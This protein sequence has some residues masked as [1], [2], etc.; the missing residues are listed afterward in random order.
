MPVDRSPTAPLR[1]AIVAPSDFTPSPASTRA[2]STQSDAANQSRDVTV[3]AVLQADNPAPEYPPDLLGRR[4][5]GRV[6][7]EFV[8]DERGRVDTRTLRIISS[9]HERFSEAVRDVLPSLR[10]IPAQSDG[11][12]TEERVEMPFRF[13]PKPE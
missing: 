13:S 4:M 2:Q 9:T 6:V 5:E 8:V 1:A 3:H 11:V 7:A 10:F 12:R